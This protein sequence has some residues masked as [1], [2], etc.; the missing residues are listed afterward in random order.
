MNALE[1]TQ[2]SVDAWNRHDADFIVALYAE[3]GTYSAP[4]RARLLPGRPLPTMQKRCGGPIP[5]CPSKSL[6]QGIPVKA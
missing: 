4:A 2:R 6:V 5:T 1:V 3:G